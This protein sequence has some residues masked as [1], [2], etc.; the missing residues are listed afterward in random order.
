MPTVNHTKT[1][2]VFSEWRK[3]M[4]RRQGVSY[5]DVDFKKVSPGEMWRLAEEQLEAAGVPLDLRQQ[6][7]DDFNVYLELLQQ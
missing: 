5:Q 1:F 4:A 2:K 3:E 7:F 6:Y